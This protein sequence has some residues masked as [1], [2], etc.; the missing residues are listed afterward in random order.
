MLEWGIHTFNNGLHSARGLGTTEHHDHKLFKEA[1]VIHDAPD[2]PAEIIEIP[3]GGPR[4]AGTDSA[5]GAAG[6]T[7][8]MEIGRDAPVSYAFHFE[9]PSWA[10]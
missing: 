9:Y 7:G 2:G 3:K 1:P 8:E 6:A 5:V 10:E 4:S